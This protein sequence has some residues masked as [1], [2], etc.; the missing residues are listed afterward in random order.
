MSYDAN[1]NTP[2]RTGKRTASE[3]EKTDM[4]HVPITRIRRRHRP[5]STRA[6]AKCSRDVHRAI[7]KDSDRD[8]H[9]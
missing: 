1:E 8:E 2:S 5:L 9:E 6:S 4:T 7:S 3:M